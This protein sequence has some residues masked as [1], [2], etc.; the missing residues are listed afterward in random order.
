MARSVSYLLFKSFIQ[1]NY[2]DLF[3]GCI[4]SQNGFIF[5]IILD[6]EN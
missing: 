1:I 6:I 4:K 5:I 3:I 2:F